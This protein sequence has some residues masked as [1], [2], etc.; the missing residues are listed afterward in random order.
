MNLSWLAG[1]SGLKPAAGYGAGACRAGFVWCLIQG[2]I[3]G[4]LMRAGD[5]YV[6][7][8]AVGQFFY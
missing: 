5:S 7:D 6:I 1:C 2:F 3:R 4:G 8:F